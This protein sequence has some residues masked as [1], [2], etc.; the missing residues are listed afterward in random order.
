MLLEWCYY[1]FKFHNLLL[2]KY[3]QFSFQEEKK[4]SL[5]IW[6][7]LILLPTKNFPLQIAFL[8]FILEKFY[9]QINKADNRF[10]DR[11][12]ILGENDYYQISHDH[13]KLQ[14]AKHIYHQIPI[15]PP[16]MSLRSHTIVRAKAEL[17]AKFMSYKGA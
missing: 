3:I 6:P 2:F 14:I 8:F 5:F 11:G 10:N 4:E 1:F 13:L 9:K 12:I 7:F 17:N 16:V 15:L